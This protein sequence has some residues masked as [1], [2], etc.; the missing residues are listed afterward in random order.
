[1]ARHDL[2]PNP[3]GERNPA[4]R[5]LL[6]VEDLEA[7]YGLIPVLHGVS[8]SVGAGETVALL[9]PNGAGKST[10]LRAVSGLLHPR[11][12]RI[13]LDG[14]PIHHLPPHAIAR[15]GLAHVP[16]GR[17]ILGRLTVRENLELGF[18]PHGRREA[19]RHDLARVVELFPRLGERLDQLAGTLSGGEQQMLAIGRALMSHPRLL[20]LDEPSMGLAPVLVEA[21]YAVL[22]EI[23]AT[24][25]AILL[26][27]Q[28]VPLALAVASR[29]YVLEAGQ[30]VAAAPA[31]EL[32][33]SE[34]VRR[35][36]L[37]E[38]PADGP[39]GPPA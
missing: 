13:L 24:G 34:A 35:A 37:G 30:V 21:I 9:G 8:L 16:E 25:A 39:P 1:M 2:V 31:H 14:R 36:Y 27:E 33:G 22:P 11:R 38:A 23:A 4:A 26:V 20:L 28:N 5:P 19:L 3:I 17:G 6:E 29:G 12:G 15:L 7:G 10:T 18:F 32:L